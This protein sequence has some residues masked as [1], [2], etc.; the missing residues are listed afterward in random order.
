[1]NTGPNVCRGAKNDL[2]ME[3]NVNVVPPHFT[4]IN[5]PSWVSKGPP[6]K[7]VT[8]SKMVKRRPHNVGYHTG[9]S[10]PIFFEA[11]ITPQRN[12]CR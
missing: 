6:E 11:H 4:S 3:T 1:M 2:L 12:E 8:L 7:I 9:P 10:K 5:I